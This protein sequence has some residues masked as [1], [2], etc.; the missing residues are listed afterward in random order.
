MGLMEPQGLLGPCDCSSAAPGRAGSGMPA[1]GASRTE[2]FLGQWS[3]EVQEF[4]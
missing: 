1:L 4:D 2:I 3:K